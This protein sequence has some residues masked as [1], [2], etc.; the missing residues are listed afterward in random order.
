MK[1]LSFRKSGIHGWGLY[2]EHPIEA[3][4]M[5]IEY[6]GE[7]ISN[8]VCERREHTYEKS[9]QGSSYMFRINRNEVIDA[10]RTGGRARYGR[11]SQKLTRL[12]AVNQRLLQR[13]DF[14]LEYGAVNHSCEPNCYTRIINVGGRPKVVLYSKR[15][16]EEGEELSYDYKFPPEGGTVPCHCGARRCRGFM[17]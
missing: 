8:K 16:I 1:Q 13:A 11:Y 15:A 2:A 12:C 10:T 14:F 6:K 4:E 3:E 9:G 17:A 7:I 5:V